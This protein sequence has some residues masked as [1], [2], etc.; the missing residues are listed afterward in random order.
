MENVFLSDVVGRVRYYL[1]NIDDDSFEV[2]IKKSVYSI[3]LQKEIVFAPGPLF[4]SKLFLSD[5]L[6]KSNSEI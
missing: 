1:L 3:V 6:F 4:A 2:I 5:D